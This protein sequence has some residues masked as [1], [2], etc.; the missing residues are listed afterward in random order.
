[1]NIELII[2]LVLLLYIIYLHSL[3]H[4]KSN[5]IESLLK[6]QLNKENLSSREEIDFLLNRLKSFNYESLYKANKLFDREVQEFIFRDFDNEVIFVHYTKTEEIAESIC[7]EGFRFA[8]SF[9]KTTEPFITDRLDQVY[10]HNLRRQF[11]NFVVVIAIAK[12]VYTKY[13]KAVT[14]LNIVVNVEQ[15]LSQAQ[16]SV[17]GELDEIYLLPPQYVKGYIN[18]ETGETV[19]NLNYK[20]TFES[21]HFEQNIIALQKK[22]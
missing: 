21:I 10:K 9:Y 13:T 17:K 12:E 19:P 16:P 8:E 22:L 11:G 15:I 1:M 18:I 3:L 7:R 5:R 20:P 2:I 4:K 6:Q 14:K